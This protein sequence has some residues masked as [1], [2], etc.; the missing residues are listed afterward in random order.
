MKDYH[1]DMRPILISGLQSITDNLGNSLVVYP[2]F[3]EPYI[4][5]MLSKQIMKELLKET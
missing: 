4:K 1:L 2:E 5:W 3:I